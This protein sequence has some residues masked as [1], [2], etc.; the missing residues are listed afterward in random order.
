MTLVTKGKDQAYDLQ[1]RAPVDSHCPK[2]EKVVEK[3]LAIRDEI[4]AG[5]PLGQISSGKP[6]AAP[7]LVPAAAPVKFKFMK[8]SEGLG[9]RADP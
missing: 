9:V 5:D 8:S 1:P 2:L 7:S 3:S 6:S 4:I